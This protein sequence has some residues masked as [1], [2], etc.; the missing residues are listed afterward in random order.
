MALTTA[1]RV[2]TWGGNRFGQLGDGSTRDRHVPGYVQLP[3]HTTISSVAAGSAM[4]YAV[5]S[6]GRL[7]SWG[8]NNLGQV[9]DGTTRER[10]TPVAIRLPGG[11]RVVAAIAGLLNVLALTTDRRALGWG[12][13]ARGQL[14]DQSTTD[15]HQPYGCACR[16]G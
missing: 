12:Y 7:L 11:V 6:A 5:T 13:N 8:I 9:G 14:G 4:G 3:R 2:L 16:T 10:K 15:R 1:G